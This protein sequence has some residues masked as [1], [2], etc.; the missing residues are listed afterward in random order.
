M[1]P[2]SQMMGGAMQNMMGGIMQQAMAQL[3]Q[4]FGVN[5]PS[6]GNY[7]QM[8]NALLQNEEIQKQ[9]GPFINGKNLE[10]LNE[11]F[12]NL[13]NERGIDPDKFAQRMGVTLPK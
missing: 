3:M 2:I 1:N 10:Q 12:R 8:T 6:N 4:H 5:M 7:Q 11:T 13:C 9:A